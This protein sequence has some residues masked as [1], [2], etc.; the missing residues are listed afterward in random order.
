MLSSDRRIGFRVPIEM[1]LN[2][3][4]SDRPY[5]AMAGN[6]S[7]TGILLN[8]VKSPPRR[9]QEG[10][11]VVGLEFELPGTSETIWARGEICS[12]GSD[13]FFQT[14]RVRFTGMPRIHARMLRNYCI[15]SRRS[16]LGGL[17]GRIRCSE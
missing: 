10:Q 2:Q 12:Q 16:H 6:L 14:D 3:Y 7:E 17:L 1:F 11:R 15:E 5:R 13:R 9:L 8:R 4:I